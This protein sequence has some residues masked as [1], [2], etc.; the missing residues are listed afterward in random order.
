MHTQVRRT[1]A[2]GILLLLLLSAGPVSAVAQDQP[3]EAEPAV[4]PTPVEP[5]PLLKDPQATLRTF[6]RTMREGDTTG[7]V[8]C[9]DLSYLSSNVIAISGPNVAHQVK[10][11]LDRLVG[12]TLDTPDEVWGKIPDENDH[13]E[14]F[15][16]SAIE[17]SL[18]QARKIVIGRGEDGN[19]RFTEETCRAA[20]T[21]YNEF[22]QM[23]TLVGEE[24]EAEELATAPF[25]MRLRQWFPSPLR[26]PHFVLP[27]YQWI[28]L[29]LVIFLGQ[30]G[31]ASCRERV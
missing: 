19:W 23:P 12:I 8:E 22:E 15:L 3:A 27:D 26:Q 2:I 11:A 24:V 13:A 1:N 4:Q 28:C 16:L 14:P 6:L 20:E 9:L 17:G 30:I 10:T 18:K 31:R 7:A 29:L 5:N 21:Y 25:P